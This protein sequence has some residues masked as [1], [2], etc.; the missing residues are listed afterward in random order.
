MHARERLL[1]VIVGLVLLPMGQAALAGP[2]A[3]DNTALPGWFGSKSFV[4]QNL[5]NVPLTATIDYAVYAPGDYVNSPALQGNPIPSSPIDPSGGAHYVYAY[6][7][8]TT[9]VQ[10]V[11]DLTVGLTAGAVALGSTDIGTYSFDPEFGVVPTST[12]ITIPAVRVSNAKWTKT[13]LILQNDHSNILFFTSAFGPQW[14]Q[15]SLGGGGSFT[16][17]ESLPSPIPEPASL[18][19]VGTAGL[20]LLARGILRRRRR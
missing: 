18:V 9:S 19:L 4:G 1:C 17:Q 11:K 16:A 20:L 15:S 10:G 8:H 2:L 5:Q 3:T 6:Q 7:I 12:F 14:F 13:T